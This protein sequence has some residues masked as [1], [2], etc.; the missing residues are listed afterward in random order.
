M[1][2]F[3]R[4]VV[5]PVCPVPDLTHSQSHVSLPHIRWARGVLNSVGAVAVTEA[6]VP[7]SP[8]LECATMPE[9]LPCSEFAKAKS[10]GDG[11][12]DSQ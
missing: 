1:S 10:A 7:R 11:S 4:S 9:L 6:V 12:S 3:C 2:F 5:L 8:F